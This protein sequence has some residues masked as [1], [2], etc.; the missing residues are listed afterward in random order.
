MTTFFLSLEAGGICQLTEKFELK[1]L[2]RL[3]ISD[4]LNPDIRTVVSQ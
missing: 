3:D 1:L 2:E 4:N